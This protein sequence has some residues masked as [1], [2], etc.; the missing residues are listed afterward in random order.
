MTPQ[1]SGP[2]RACSTTSSSTGIATAQC[3]GEYLSRLHYLEDW[4]ADNDRRGL[5]KDLTRELGRRPR[6]A[7]RA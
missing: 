5:V 7:R 6:P 1:A 3:T 4:L 2:R